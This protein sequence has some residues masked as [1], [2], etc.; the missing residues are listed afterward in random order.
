M[1]EF[2][3]AIFYTINKFCQS[4]HV[5]PPGIVTESGQAVAAHHAL[6]SM[7]VIQT[8]DPQFHNLCSQIQCPINLYIVLRENFYVEWE[9]FIAP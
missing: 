1:Q 4:E 8:S 7:S 6:F 2:A 5:P 9:E 3:N